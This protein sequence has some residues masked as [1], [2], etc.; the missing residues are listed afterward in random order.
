MSSGILVVFITTEPQ[1][2]LHL[3]SFYTDN[4]QFQGWFVLTFVRP[5]LGI[6]A[7]YVMATAWSSCG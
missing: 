7:A 2:E 3:D 5:F 1:R 4:L 6:T